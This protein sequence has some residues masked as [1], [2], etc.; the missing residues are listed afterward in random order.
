MDGNQRRNPSPF[1]INPA[2]KVTGTLGCNHDNVNIRGWNHRLEMNAEPVREAENLS[3]GQPRFDRRVVERSLGLVGSKN[4]D[5]VRLLGGF[6][7]S[8]N[9]KPV[10]F[11]LLGALAGRIQPDNHVVTAIAQVLGLGVSLAAVSENGDGLALQGNWIGVSLIKDGGHD[12]LP[13]N[14]H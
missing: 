4:L 6:R 10:G 3:F 2:Q 7:G 13:S 14:L 9:S 11:R 12:S 8:E 1:R 5:P